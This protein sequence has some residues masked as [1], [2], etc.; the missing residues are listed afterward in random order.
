MHHWYVQYDHGRGQ[1]S[2]VLVEVPRWAEVVS[3]LVDLVDGRSGH[4]FCHSRYFRS[5]FSWLFFL[6]SRHERV[7][8]SF[9]LA[10]SAAWVLGADVYDED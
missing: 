9:P 1:Y 2:A 5:A 10:A 8:H 6:D 4:K 7:V 3:W